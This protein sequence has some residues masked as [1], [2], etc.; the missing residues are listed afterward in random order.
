MNSK[1]RTVVEMVHL[2]R[3]ELAGLYDDNEVN[4]F[5]FLMFEEYVGLSKTDIVLKASELLEDEALKNIDAAVKRLKKHEPIQHIIGS[6]EFFGLTIK[7]DARAMIPRPETEELVNWIIKEND[8]KEPA[9]LDVGTGTGCIAL[10]LQSSI[11]V[12]KIFAL[13]ISQDA[14]T[15][16]KENSLVNKLDIRLIK[17]DVL[18]WRID[19]QLLAL[20]KFDIIVSNPPYIEK[21]LSSEMH[22]NVLK[23]E[24]H[25]ALFVNDGE[26][27]VFYQAIIEL[28]LD[29]MNPGGALFFEISEREGKRV[30]ALLKD[31]G[32]DE[33]ELRKDLS[34]KDRMV[35][36]VRR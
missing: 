32:F 12:A 11:A 19:K 27:M 13:D 16:T 8:D 4:S 33:I 3:D 10:A 25:Q 14:L 24:P 35:K 20:P 15:L 34:G 1:S 6:T 30:Y 31:S 7:T 22:E 29:K 36:S 18:N 5:I 28:A 17:A 2:I 23:Y 21:S 26:S 9:I